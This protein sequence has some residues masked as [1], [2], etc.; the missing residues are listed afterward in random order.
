MLDIVDD[1][2]LLFIENFDINM[3]IELLKNKVRY[4]YNK[5]LSQ[6]AKEVF[7]TK[8]KKYS[9]MIGVYPPQKIILKN[10]KK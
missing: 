2:L 4:L 1:N 9:K 5:W 3:N 10:L 6:Q 7:V 8:I